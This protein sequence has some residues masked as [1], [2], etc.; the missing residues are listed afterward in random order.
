LAPFFLASA[1]RALASADSFLR[2]AGLI[3]FRAPAFFAEVAAF[4][5]TDL[6]SRC[7]HRSLIAAEMRLRVAAPIVRVPDPASAGRPRRG[8]DLS[9]TAI[10]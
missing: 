1:H 7:A 9:R 2:A 6:P 4:F 8:L 3:G 5:G 10:A